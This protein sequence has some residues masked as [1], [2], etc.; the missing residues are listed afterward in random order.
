MMNRNKKLTEK[1]MDKEK[2]LKKIED[3]KW[4]ME[5]NYKKSSQTRQR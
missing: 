5:E 2:E 1:L 4:Q 3:L